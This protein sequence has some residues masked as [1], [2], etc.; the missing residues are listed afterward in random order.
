MKT[1]KFIISEHCNMNCV[2]CD[3][4]VNNREYLSFIKFKQFYNSLNINEDYY[5]DIFGGEPLLYSN[6]CLKIVKFLN[7]D[8]NCKSINITTNGTIFDK[9]VEKIISYK[10]TKIN[11]SYD[12]IYQ[13]QNRGHNKLY[14]NEIINELNKVNKLIRIHSMLVGEMFNNINN[15]I[16]LKQHNNILEKTND[17]K[18]I[19][20]LTVVRDINIWTKEQVKQYNIQLKE[21]SQLII[22]NIKNNMY[23]N[24]EEI[25]GLFRIP[26]G[27]LLESV[28]VKNFKQPT[29]GVDTGQN[30][31]NINNNIIPCERFLRDNKI[32]DELK[33]N[34]LKFILEHCHKCSIEHLC[35]KGCIYEQ[36]KNKHVIEELCDIY[37]ESFRIAQYIIQ[38]TGNT[39]IK[40]YIKDSQNK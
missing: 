37:K 6:I 27:T 24:F 18:T 22:N 4:D 1:I 33:N 19:V 9:Y 16:L 23:N 5:F 17:K 11:I 21:Y 26:L 3:V 32:Y 2:Y 12:G 31:T 8:K 14:I 13:K 40:M 7:K 39:L 34:K 20:D 30:I 28:L 25:P 29:C 15:N 38:Q 10:K 35:N 36:I